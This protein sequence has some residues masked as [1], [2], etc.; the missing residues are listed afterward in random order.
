[1]GATIAG[2]FFQGGV[3]RCHAQYRSAAV[4]SRVEHTWRLLRPSPPP[5]PPPPPPRALNNFVSL[6]WIDPVPPDSPPCRDAYAFL[7][8]QKSLRLAAENRG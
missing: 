3:T 5:L 6:N 7:S 2:I 1:M 4:T 8:R